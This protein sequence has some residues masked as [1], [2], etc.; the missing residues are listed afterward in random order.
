MARI[1]PLPMPGPLSI[2]ER[3]TL[4]RCLWCAWHPMAMRERGGHHPEC[5]RPTK[6]REETL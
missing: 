1:Y 4:G 6:D 3:R 2:D 5:P